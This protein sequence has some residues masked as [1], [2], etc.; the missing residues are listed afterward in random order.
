M[1]MLLTTT[2]LGSVRTRTN[3]LPAI[4]TRTND[5]PATT[6]FSA[7]LANVSCFR[8]PSIVRTPAGALVAFAEARHG[9]CGD[10]NVYEIA[11]RRSTDDGATWSD[12][13]FAV[14]NSSFRVGNPTAVATVAGDIVLVYVTHNHGK[15]GDPGSGTGIV[16]SA[17]GGLTW[18]AP[19]DISAGFGVASGALPGPGTALQLAGPVVPAGRLLVVSHLGAYQKDYVSYSDDLGDTWTTVDHPFPSMDEALAQL[20]SRSIYL[21]MRQDSPSRAAASR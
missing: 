5:L 15:T 20:P 1:L 17:D 12:V 11:Y 16:T 19:R 8:I 2:L 7:G 3:D 9:S 10:G 18:S 13:G 6:V 14:G 21:N 4:R